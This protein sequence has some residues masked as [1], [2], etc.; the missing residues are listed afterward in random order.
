MDEAY[1]ILLERG[2]TAPTFAEVKAHV[3]H[4]RKLEAVGRLV[5][6]GPFTDDSGGVVVILADSL[7][8]AQE[9]AAN[10]PFVA[11][12]SHTFTVREYEWSMAA[13]DHLGVFNQ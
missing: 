6:C 10:D 9:F 1:L 4:L 7:K 13:N 5:T 12:G 3:E 8:A 11:A 2:E